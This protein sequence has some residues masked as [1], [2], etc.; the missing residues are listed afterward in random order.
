MSVKKGKKK[1]RKLIQSG[2]AHEEKALNGT[3]PHQLPSFSLDLRVV[4]RLVSGF[5]RDQSSARLDHEPILQ[6]QVEEVRL[7]CNVRWPRVPRPTPKPGQVRVPD[8]RIGVV[9]RTRP[10]L[11]RN[12]ARRLLVS[13]I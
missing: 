9:G 1:E 7:Q 3:A 13:S 6:L 2:V 4:V 8:V 11:F 10:V 5:V 12:S